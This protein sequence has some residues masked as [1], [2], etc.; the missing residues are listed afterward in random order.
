MRAPSRSASPPLSPPDLALTGLLDGEA[1][2]SGTAGAPTGDYR[3]AVSRLVAPQTASAGLPP[4]DAGAT[5]RLD[6]RRATIEATAKAG[7]AGTLTIRG[8]L[9]LAATG[10]LDLAVAGHVDA[11]LANRTMAAGGRSVAGVVAIDGRLTGPLQHPQVAGT[12]NL[13]DGTF[14]DAGNGIRLD[15]IRARLVARG[16]TVTIES[17]SAAT[18]DGGSIGATGQVRLDA[19][20]GFPGTIHVTGR[21]ARLVQS[22]VATA[23]VNLDLTITGA[24]ARDP[25]LGGRLDIVSLDIPVPERLAGRLQ[26]LP[27]TRH[28]NPT[29]TAVRRL[30]LQARTS[31]AG[32]AGFDMALDLTIAV[33][34][35]IHVY[36]RGLDA[37]LGGGLRLTGTLEKPRPVGAFNLQHGNLQI[38]TANL[39]FSRANLTFAGDLAPELDFLATTQAGGA[40]I[41]IAITGQPSD[42]QFTFTSSPDLPQDEILSR[43]LFG[44]P[45][46][47]LSTS[48][49]L[50]LASAVAQYSTGG[51]GD[52]LEGLRRSLGFGAAGLSNNPLA[53]ALGNRV[54]VGVHTGVT[55]AETGVGVDVSLFGPLKV[56]GAVN[57]NGGTSVGV[58]AEHEW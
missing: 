58:G 37:S 24:L 14:A 44:A 2:L 19:A 20:A 49:A 52:A 33:P 22:S 32:K 39:D 4:I 25:R 27:G 5:G 45:A 53:N 42:P 57:A 50:S 56:Q 41:G 35:R 54:S 48:Q 31:R 36:G 17:A 28:R 16:D 7:T 10:A 23:V 46:G 13:A 6:G 8:S 51:G 30:A 18:R 12:A 40:S 55:P 47:Q 3:L 15:A 38:L 29:P 1:T 43:L 26:P 21:N 34:G 9:P 11:A